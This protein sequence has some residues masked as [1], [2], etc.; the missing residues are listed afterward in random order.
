[1]TSNESISYGNPLAASGDGRSITWKCKCGTSD[2]AGFSC[3]GWRGLN[4][5]KGINVYNLRTLA[6]TFVE[7]IW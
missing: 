5:H 7:G 4:I 2:L 6:K 1:V 3:C